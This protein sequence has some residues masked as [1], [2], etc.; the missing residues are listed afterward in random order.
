MKREA[1]N[2]FAL[3]IELIYNISFLLL[4]VMAVTITLTVVLLFSRIPVNNYNFIIS[5]L[6]SIGIFYL[7]KKKTNSHSWLLISVLLGCMILVAC[8]YCSSQVMDLS[9]DGNTYHKDAVGA[10]KNGWNPIREDYISFYEKSGLRD[11][12]YIGG[13]IERTH[14]FWQTWYAKG[15]WY[16]SADIYALT[17]NIESGKCYTMI[18]MLILL[19]FVSK[20]IYLKQGSFSFSLLCGVLTAFTPVTIVQM[21]SY[22]NDGVLALL[23]SGVVISFCLLLDETIEM[24]KT[25]KYIWICLFLCL[26]IQVKFT[27]LAYGGVFCILLYAIFLIKKWKTKELVEIRNSVTIF[28]LLC[29]ISIGVVGFNPYVTNTLNTGNPFYPLLGKDKV[30]I[31]SY[32][33]PVSFHS[34]GTITKFV[35]SLFSETA[36]INEASGKEPKWKLPFTT[37]RQEWNYLDQVD[38]RIGGYGIL[39]S[40]IFLISIFIIFSAFIHLRKMKNPW[41]I[42]CSGILFVLIVLCITISESWWARYSPYLYFIPLMAVVLSYFCWK[43][44]ISRIL[45]DVLAV[46]MVINLSYFVSSS[47]FVRYHDSKQETAQLKEL[48][49]KEI[50]LYDQTEG[51]LGYLYNLDDLNIRYE[52]TKKPLTSENGTLFYKRIRYSIK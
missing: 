14:G 42:V 17:N 10:L 49:G 25:E 4:L 24:K 48:S 20:V 18:F 3:F 26:L 22:Y 15:M 34:S 39:F 21:F 28:T 37:N 19:G 44:R 52:A 38:V 43:S 6:L 50:L 11:M 13:K 23:L 45:L 7:I 2:R 35:K 16:L 46:L 47:W 9:W 29:V 36:N 1:E 12:D 33:E 8:I 51:F 27:G 5:C 40:G 32:N 31:V 41:F 30:D